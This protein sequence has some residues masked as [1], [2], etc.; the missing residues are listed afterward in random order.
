MGSNS[1]AWKTILIYS[2]HQKQR[3][4]SC[5]LEFII[6]AYKGMINF[7][8]WF[9]KINLQYLNNDNYLG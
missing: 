4:D 2:L 6:R 7:P 1:T 5:K 9:I 8:D 3:N